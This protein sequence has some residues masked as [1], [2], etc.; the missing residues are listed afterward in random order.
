MIWSFGPMGFI[1]VCAI[2]VIWPTI[3]VW[4]A[5]ST[6]SR[7]SDYKSIAE[8]AVSAQQDMERELIEVRL[9]LDDMGDRVKSVER[10]L[11]DV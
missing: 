11:K 10:V 4:R 3:A 6:M 9:Q 1:V 5:K 2:R 8:R 7:E